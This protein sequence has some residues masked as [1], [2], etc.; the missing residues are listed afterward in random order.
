M[1]T[2]SAMFLVFGLLC[3]SVALAQDPPPPGDHHPG[4]PSGDMQQMD[5]NRH[6]PAAQAQEGQMQFGPQMND[7]MPEPQR[8][9]MGEQRQSLDPPMP[10]CGPMPWR[11]AHRCHAMVLLFAL[12]HRIGCG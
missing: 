9:K 3:A 6:A 12:V 4:S 1:R 8:M 7:S 11:H 10:A 5:M 2:V